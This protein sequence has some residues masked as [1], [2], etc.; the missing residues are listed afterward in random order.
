MRSPLTPP[1]VLVGVTS[2]VHIFETDSVGAHAGMYTK[3]QRHC[4][5]SCQGWKKENVSHIYTYKCEH[6]LFKSQRYICVCVFMKFT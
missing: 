2:A 4:R 1:S 6:V 3:S 5:G